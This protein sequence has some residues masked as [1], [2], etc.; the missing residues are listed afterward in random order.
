MIP[1]FLIL[2]LLF[3]FFC[4]HGNLAQ[5]LEE[6]ATRSQEQ[7]SYQT[8]IKGDIQEKIRNTLRQIS[9]TV[10]LEERPLVSI[11]Q[12]KRRAREDISEFVGALR[13]F[14]YYA[15][16]I[17]YHIQEDQEPVQV[18]FEIDPGPEYYLTDVIMI[19]KD[20]KK[21]IELPEPRELG[22]MQ[23]ERMEA[24]PV[25]EA[26]RK[27]NRYLRSKGFPFPESK[28]QEVVIDH[29]HQSAAVHMTFDPGPRAVFGEAEISG[30]ERVEPGFILEKIPWKKG[31]EKFQAPK[32]DTLRRELTATG[33]FSVVEIDHA[34]S[35]ENDNLP[36]NIRVQER[37]PRTFRAGVG[38]HT[39]IGPEF[40]L[41]W[42]HRNLRGR[43]ENLEIDLTLSEVE[44]ALETEYTIPSF[45]R[46]DQNLI[47]K[48]GYMEEYTDA[49]DATSIFTSAT[50]DRQLTQE[51]SLGGGIG[52]RIS[53][54]EQLDEKTD[55]GLLYFPT[56]LLYDSREDVLDPSQG[57]RFNL[58]LT[59]FLDT[60]DPETAFLKGYTS[61]NNYWEIWPQNKI[62]LANRLAYGS[63]GAESRNKVPPDERFYAGGGGSIRGYGYQEVGPMVD[64]EPIGALSK[65][66]VNAELRFR[67]TQRSGIVTFLDGGQAY[68]DSYPDFSQDLQWGA[69]I[70]YRFFTDFGPFRADIAFPLNPRDDI[71][72]TFQLY[73][74]L[75]QAF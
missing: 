8:H 10:A 36:M 34:Q 48:A 9:D 66:E 33:L 71:D 59:P 20:P 65:F 75:G 70:G 63:I 62:V 14:G 68:E 73:L 1:R 12:L 37:A 19:N 18:I 27:L 24:K 17:V 6:P 54:V 5:A 47:L 7:K 3:L 16:D 55:L 11:G 39:D 30:L 52:Y 57:M 21:D 58:R 15:P 38:Y 25:S 2:F 74:S 28:I 67:L 72:D 13:S 42:R 22:L 23:G 56:N 61:L 51:L 31:E 43:G 49:Y 4:F 32:M 40:R 45:R 60:W 35:L 46:P 41:G 44:R 29:A 64:Q 50:M 53:Q 26:P 69:G